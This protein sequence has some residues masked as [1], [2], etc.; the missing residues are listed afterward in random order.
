DIRLIE[1]ISSSGR[2]V[3]RRDSYSRFV[4]SHCTRHIVLIVAIIITKHRAIANVDSSNLMID[5]RRSEI[6]TCTNMTAIGI[7]EESGKGSSGRKPLEGRNSA[8]RGATIIEVFVT[9]CD[10]SFRC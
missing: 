10:H 1:K 4:R 8:V 7:A 9:D 2:I 3:I 6:Y 5:A